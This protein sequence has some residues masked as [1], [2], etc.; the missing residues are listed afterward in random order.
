MGSFENQTVLV[1][2]AG[3][4]IGSHLA[5]HLVREGAKVRALVHYN[6]LGKRGWLDHSDLA[7]DM[8]ILA[9]DIT[10]R[11]SV[12][13]AVKGCGTVFHLAALIAIPYSYQAPRSY[14]RANIEGTLNVMQSAL[15]TG[16]RRVLNTSTSEVYGTARF[17][18][19][20]EEH[21]LQGQ[22]PY[23]ASKIGADK[24]AEA[25]AASYEL[26][27]VT[28]RPFNTFGP[29]QSMRAVIPT[30]ITQCLRGDEVRLGAVTPTRDLNYVQ[31]TVE[32]F[33]AA[34]LSPNAAGEVINFGSGRE[35][36]IGDLAVL[37]G[38]MLGKD[39]RV[40]CEQERLRPS[41]SEVERLLAC[42]A[43][44]RS[45]LGWE[46]RVSLEEGLEKTLAWLQENRA[47]YQAQGYVV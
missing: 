3:G 2:G 39:I 6:A 19:I 43:K 31:N 12:R 10:D 27:V 37:I 15:E 16:A 35:I 23:S 34:A 11:D 1:T 14:V 28:V 47:H 20:T 38:K 40:V 32:G 26:E 8:E 24:M 46:P 13:A 30:I 5:E 25:F 4:F 22:S 21:P 17:V 44:A 29:R 42:N 41:K 33:C 45:L 36:S 18:P 9:G 7:G